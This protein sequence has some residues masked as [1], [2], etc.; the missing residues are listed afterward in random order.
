VE[1]DGVLGPHLGGSYLLIFFVVQKIGGI[2]CYSFKDIIYQL[3]V[4][5][6]GRDK[7]STKGYG[8]DVLLQYAVLAF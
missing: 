4:R 5:A 1:G 8:I 2:L 6:F 3:L 7:T